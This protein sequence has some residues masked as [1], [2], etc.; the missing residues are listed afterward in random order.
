MPDCAREGLYLLLL[1]IFHN[2]PLLQPRAQTPTP[3][4]GRRGGDRRMQ[5]WDNSGLPRNSMRTAE[6]S[7]WCD[8]CLGAVFKGLFPSSFWGTCSPCKG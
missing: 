5:H 1:L 7:L 6:H 2:A 3:E 4:A 8:S